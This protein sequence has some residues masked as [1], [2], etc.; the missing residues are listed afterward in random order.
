MK[1]RIISLTIALGYIAFA[2]FDGGLVTAL[3]V[4]AIVLLPLACIWFSDTMG[5]YTGVNFGRGQ[6]NKTTPGCLVA[7]G[8]WFL[9]L[10]PPIWI[11]A[12]AL[13][14]NN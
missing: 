4:T 12:G 6:I 14:S 7:F 5:G 3:R 1:S 8:G 11:I 13:S 10:S 9:L 2:Y